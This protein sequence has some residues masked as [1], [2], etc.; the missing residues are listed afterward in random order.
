MRVHTVCS[1]CE[2]QRSQ[3]AYQSLTPVQV[4]HFKKLCTSVRQIVEI[5]G[6][7]LSALPRPFRESAGAVPR[8]RGVLYGGGDG[9]APFDRPPR[10]RARL[11]ATVRARWGDLHAPLLLGL[12]VTR[13]YRLETRVVGYIDTN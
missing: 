4:K 12:V 7:V 11:R 2:R 3:S 9:V 8:A 10:A 6:W 5:V 1:T 13:V